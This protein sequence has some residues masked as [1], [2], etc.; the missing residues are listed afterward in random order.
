MGLRSGNILV[1]DDTKENLR[2]LV[3][4]LGH[5]G[6]VVRPALSGQIALEAARKEPPDLILLDV[7]MP[8][9]NG[10]QVCAALKADTH[11]QDVPV[12]FISALDEVTDKVKGFSAGGVDYISKP[13]QTEELLARVETHLILRNLTKRIEDKNARLQEVNEALQRA[14]DEIKTLRGIIPICAHCKKIRDDKGYWEQIETY[15]HQHSDAEFSHSICRECAK[16]H[17][18]DFDIYDE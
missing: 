14:L 8:G 9:M 11:L 18:P 13:F 17:Y 5:E 16:V 15:I 3:D 2:I 7:I 6:Y 10:Y 12:I 1:V 4:A